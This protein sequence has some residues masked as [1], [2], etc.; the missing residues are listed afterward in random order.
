MAEAVFMHKVRAA[1]L[2]HAIG[3]ESAG[4]GDW[5]VGKPPHAGT[6]GLLAKYDI[7]YDHCAR[8]LTRSDL[9]AFDYIITMDD[10]NFRDVQQLGLGP[11]RIARFLEFAP[12]TEEREV[13]D[14]YYTGEFERVYTLVDAAAEGLLA[15]IRQEH[16]F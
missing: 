16:G 15:S 8:L 5:H 12:G 11:A 14:P 6:R 9:S 1:D 3:A 2:D 4:T 13:P 10:Q 7:T